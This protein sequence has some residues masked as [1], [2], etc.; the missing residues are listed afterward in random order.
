MSKKNKYVILITLLLVASF[1]LGYILAELLMS[2]PQEKPKS[3]YEI[4]QEGYD[5]VNK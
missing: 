5:R 4:I 1:S 3:A 2:E